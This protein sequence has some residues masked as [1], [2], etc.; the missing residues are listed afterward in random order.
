VQVGRPVVQAHV[1]RDYTDVGSVVG[2]PVVRV[3]GALRFFELHVGGLHAHQAV[4]FV[5]FYEAVAEFPE[6]RKLGL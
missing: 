6:E 3:F 1:Y 4:R 5:R 2:Q